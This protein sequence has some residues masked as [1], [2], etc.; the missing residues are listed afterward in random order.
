MDQV[1]SVIFYAIEKAIKSYRRFAQKQLK[2]GGLNITVDQWLTLSA[3]HANPLLSQKQLA[4][5]VFKDNASITRIIDL[6]ARNG[7]LKRNDHGSD[8]RRSQLTI[9]SKG[10]KFII[11]ARK[12]VDNY[13]AAALRGIASHELR[14]AGKVMDLIIKN[15]K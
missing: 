4:D 15:S 10:K 11:K 6:L 8:K 7:F 5:L 13:R 1:N 14:H 3:L 12:I 9:T 2:N